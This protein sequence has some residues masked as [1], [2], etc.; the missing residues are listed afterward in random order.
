MSPV[1]GSRRP[2]R[3]AFC[4]V[5]HRMPF[6]SK[7]SVCG[8]FASGSGILYSVTSPVFGFSLPMSSPVLPVYQMLPCLS[9]L[10]PCGPECAV[11]SL[12]SFTSPV[13]GF[14]RPSTLAIWPVYQS[15]PSRAA[16]GSCGREPGVGAD[17]CCMVTFTGP[18]EL[19]LGL[20]LLRVG[21]GQV[22]E[23]HRNVLRLHR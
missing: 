19:A 23:H 7:T 4:T 22:A 6:L 16:R 20:L 15:E 1:L 2:M 10:R 3:F 5:N 12:Y 14:T 9:S 13:L 11:F 18:Y 8:S 21:L 17:H